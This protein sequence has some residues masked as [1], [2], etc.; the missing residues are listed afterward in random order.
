MRQMTPTPFHKAYTL[1]LQIKMPPEDLNIGAEISVQVVE[2]TR[3]H[4]PQATTP[5]VL[6]HL[7]R[8]PS[9]LRWFDSRTA[10]PFFPVQKVGWR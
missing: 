8:P 1:H 4:H 5:L 6:D 7:R 3:I 9:R 10:D 2:V